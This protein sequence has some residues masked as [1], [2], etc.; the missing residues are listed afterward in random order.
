MTMQRR[1]HP[2]IASQHYRSLELKSRVESSDPHALVGLLY[3]E[4]IRALDLIV[5]RCKQGNDVAASAPV[6]LAQSILVALEASL[7]FDK[8]GDLAN[9]LARIYRSARQELSA[10]TKAGDLAKLNE[11]RDAISNIAYAWHALSN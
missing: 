11:I 4:L 3:E 10:S 8:G 2:A 6:T 9:T 1:A 5:V 7:D